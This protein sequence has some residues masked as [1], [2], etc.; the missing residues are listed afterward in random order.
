M[1]NADM[2]LRSIQRITC[3]EIINTVKNIKLEKVVGITE[4]N[5]EITIPS[6]KIGVVVMMELCLRVRDRKRIADE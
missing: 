4:A 3:V 6:G 5:T 2:A 1:T